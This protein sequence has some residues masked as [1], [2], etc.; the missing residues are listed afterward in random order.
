M[1][2]ERKYSKYGGLSPTDRQIVNEV[3]R[4]H[5]KTC[6][7]HMKHPRLVRID[8][9]PLREYV[10]TIV[11]LENDAVDRLPRNSPGMGGVSCWYLTTKVGADMV[12]FPRWSD[13]S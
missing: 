6:A 5:C 8:Y 1:K 12:I 13:V 11:C 3:V 4:T 10:G 2:K 9:L 7:Y